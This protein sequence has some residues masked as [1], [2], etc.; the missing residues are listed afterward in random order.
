MRLTHIVR[1]LYRLCAMTKAE[2]SSHIEGR[3]GA[4]RVPN[5]PVE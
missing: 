2:Y 4:E 3:L 1:L 5:R